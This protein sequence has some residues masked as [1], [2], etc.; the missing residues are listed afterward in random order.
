MHPVKSQAPTTQ[1]A[2]APFMPAQRN[3]EAYRRARSAQRARRDETVWRSSKRRT[4]RRIATL[5]AEVKD[6]RSLL[7]Q[8]HMMLLGLLL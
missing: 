3:I 1:A 6:T 8:L 2:L 4:P 7:L 5:C